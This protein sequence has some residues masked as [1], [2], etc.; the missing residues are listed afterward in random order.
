MIPLKRT[1]RKRIRLTTEEAKHV[2]ELATA[3]TDRLVSMETL[4]LAMPIIRLQYDKVTVMY[5]RI[6]KKYGEVI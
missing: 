2:N 5:S 6:E 4:R 1:R 3:L